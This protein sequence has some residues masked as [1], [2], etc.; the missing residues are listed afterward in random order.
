[1][2][3]AYLNVNLKASSIDNENIIGKCLC[4]SVNLKASLIDNENGEE[5]LSHF[6]FVSCDIWV[7]LF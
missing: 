1:M 2:W 4:G 5:R 3:I 6:L 7:R